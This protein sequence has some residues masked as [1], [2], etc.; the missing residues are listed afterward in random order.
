MVSCVHTESAP[1]AAA[2]VPH[3][4]SEAVKAG[5][6]AGNINISSGGVH[7]FFWN[8]IFRSC[9]QTCMHACECSNI[10]IPLSSCYSDG[11]D[12]YLL[13]NACILTVMMI[14][15]GERMALSSEV[16]TEMMKHEALL[17]QLQAKK[18]VLRHGVNEWICDVIM[19]FSI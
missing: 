7:A 1:A 12:L 16:M 4:V 13:G 19:R 18:L 5:M 14:C 15:T 11:I 9:S 17:A 6:A 8:S 10:V 2:A 3:E